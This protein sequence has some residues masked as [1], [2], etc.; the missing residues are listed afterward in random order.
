MPTPRQH[1]LAI[2]YEKFTRNLHLCGIGKAA[3]DGSSEQIGCGR[4]SRYCVVE[5]AALVVAS[6]LVAVF[7]S[8]ALVNGPK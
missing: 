8:A 7:A 6:V 1:D 3:V 2:H 5:V 4:H